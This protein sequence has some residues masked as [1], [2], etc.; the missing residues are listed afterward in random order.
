LQCEGSGLKI[1]NIIILGVTQNPHLNLIKNLWK[2]D[3]SD[4]KEALQAKS[5]Q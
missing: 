2:E 4:G 1:N 3:H 5:K